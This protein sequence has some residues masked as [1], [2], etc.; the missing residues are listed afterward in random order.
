M[1]RISKVAKVLHI[2][3]LK[4]FRVCALLHLFT[5]SGPSVGI[6]PFGKFVSSK[7]SQIKCRSKW[8]KWYHFFYFILS[9]SL[10]LTPFTCTQQNLWSLDGNWKIFWLLSAYSSE[11]SLS[12][13]MLL[14]TDEPN[15]S[16]KFTRSIIFAFT[17]WATQVANDVGFSV[18][19][20][21][22]FSFAFSREAWSAMQNSAIF[23]TL[24]E[25]K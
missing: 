21:E 18:L 8:Q 5:R 19:L 9:L 14:Q 12:T 3:K 25:L 24:L 13:E 7:R 1:E 4:R 2:I 15:K 17:I 22:Y 6:F 11:N 23:P 20:R 16:W 10:F